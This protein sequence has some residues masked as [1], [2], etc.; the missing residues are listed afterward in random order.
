MP[1]FVYKAVDQNG[2]IVTSKV[3]EKTKQSLIKRLKN[4]GL[5]PIDILQTSFSDY[6]KTVKKSVSVQDYMKIASETSAAVKTNKLRQFTPQERIRMLLTQQQ[7]V[8]NRDLMIFTQNFYLL[9]RAGF[10]NIH[11]LSTLLQSTENLTLKG[12]IEDVLA[13]V[14]GGDYMY[15]RLEYYSDVFP[16]I[17]INLIKVGELSGSLDKS[18][19]QAMN[20]LD[21][22]SKL[23]K[24]I[25]QILIPNI[26]EF[27]AMWVLMFVGILYIIPLI[28]DVYKSMGST[29][30]LPAITLWFSNF[31]AL[32]Q[33]FWYL[34]VGVIILIILG[35]LGYI[36]TPKGRYNWDYFKYKMPLFGKL[37]FAIDFSRLTQAMLLN[38][39]NGMRIQ[40]ALEVSKSIIKNY[41]LLSIIESSINNIIIGDSW[42]KPFEDSGLTSPM[43]TEM[44]KIGMQTDLPSMMEK[45]V[46]FMQIDIDNI[47]SRIVKVLPQIMYAIVGIM[48][49]FVVVVV[50]VPCIQAYMG[51][52]LFEAAGV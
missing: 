31:V 49:I 32:V 19:D 52:W 41:V 15:T 2:I 12:I 47:I 28:Q 36:R 22:S 20:Y 50:L 35:F 6:K 13:G 40:E 42:V 29:A 37:I 48:I 21:T 1:Q 10:N 43:M 33:R 26:L 4:N 45:L 27:V 34:P 39:K 16:H 51:G 38:L 44:L 23:N 25:K 17:Y 11:A 5:T 30:T 3:Q 18:L 24:K 8:T 14:E 9:K 46:E 7:K